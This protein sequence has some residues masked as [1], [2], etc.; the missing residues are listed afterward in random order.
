MDPIPE[1]ATVEALPDAGANTSD[2]TENARRICSVQPPTNVMDIYGRSISDY[3]G[4]T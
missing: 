3:A 2:A 4:S 1:N